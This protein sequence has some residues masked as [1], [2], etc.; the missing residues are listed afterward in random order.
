ISSRNPSFSIHEAVEEGKVIVLRFAKGAGETERRMLTT[1]L[2]RR[3]YASKRV[4]DNE[5]PCYPVCDACD[6]RAT[7]ESRLHTIRSEP[8]G[9]NY[10]CVL[11]CQAP[12]NHLPGRLKNAVGNQCDTFLTFNPGTKNA[13]YV[14]EHHSVDAETLREMPR[15]KCYLRTHTSTDDNTQSY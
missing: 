13:D 2:I 14:A 12:G 5:S 15:Y 10:R 7:E 8:G 3:T 9:H 6:N 1:A 11:A 4:C